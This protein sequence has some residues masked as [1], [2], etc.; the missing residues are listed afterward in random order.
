MATFSMMKS[1]QTDTYLFFKASRKVDVLV[2][3]KMNI[4]SIGVHSLM[5]VWNG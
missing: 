4:S 5:R 2:A 3:T 1:W